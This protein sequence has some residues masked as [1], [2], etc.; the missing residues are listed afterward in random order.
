MGVMVM[1]VEGTDGWEHGEDQDFEHKSALFSLTLSEVLLIN[2]WEHQVDL[3]QGANMGLLK[4]VF[5]VNLGAFCF[6]DRERPL[7]FIPQTLHSL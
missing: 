3:Y 4:T 7:T 5:E 6:Q 1:D 2:L